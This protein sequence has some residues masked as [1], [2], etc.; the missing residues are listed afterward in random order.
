V[1]KDVEEVSVVVADMEVAVEMWVVAT[2]V[3]M[4]SVGPA[5]SGTPMLH[6][7]IAGRRGI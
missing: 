2:V 1:H 5:R 4:E 7:T 3:E 6:A